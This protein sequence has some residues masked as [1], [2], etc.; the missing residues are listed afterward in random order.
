MLAGRLAPPLDHDR[1]TAGA[2]R[3]GAERQCGGQSRIY[4]YS[5]QGPRGIHLLRV[6]SARRSSCLAGP[7]GAAPIPGLPRAD[8]RRWPINSTRDGRVGRRASACAPSPCLGGARRFAH[9][10]RLGVSKRGVG[11]AARCRPAL[12]SPASPL[13]ARGLGGRIKRALARSCASGSSLSSTLEGHA[14]IRCWSLICSL[15]LVPSFTW[16]I[17]VGSLDRI[18]SNLSPTTVARPASD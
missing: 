18:W 1:A 6:Q 2:S 9:Q 15:P 5:L 4:V 14:C 3:P 12:G 11:A 13:V 17:G 7:E 10:D 8:R 16:A